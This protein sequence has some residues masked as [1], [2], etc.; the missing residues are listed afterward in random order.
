MIGN[1]VGNEKKIMIGLG[2]IATGLGFMGVFMPVI[3]TTPFLL[4]TA[5]L[6]SRSSERFNTWLQG[7][8]MYAAYVEPFKRDGGISKKKKAQVSSGTSGSI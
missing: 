4:L 6:F 3:P 1:G 7:T 5:F 2:F 8:R